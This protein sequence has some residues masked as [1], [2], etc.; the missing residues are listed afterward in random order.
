MKG[1]KKMYVVYVIEF[2]QRGLAHAHIAVKFD[3]EPLTPDQIDDVI[4]A[5]LP[6]DPA[7]ATLVTKWM[8]HK[9]YKDKCFKKHPN[10]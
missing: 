5:E 3:K 6:E 8:T 7:S 10:M 4:S 1:G 2:Q 9:H